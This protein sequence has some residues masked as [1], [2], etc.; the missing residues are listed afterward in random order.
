ME[1]KINMNYENIGFK[2]KY[3]VV[4]KKVGCSKC[5][6]LNSFLEYGVN[7]KFDSVISRVTKEDHSET[8]DEIVEKTGAMSLPIILNVPSGN[9]IT[10]FNPPEIMEFIQV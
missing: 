3:V 10:G 9:F 2:T 5:N 7:G 4:G 6:D 8:Y 1:E